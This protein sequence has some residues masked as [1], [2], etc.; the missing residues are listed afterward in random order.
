MNKDEEER[1]KRETPIIDGDAR[2]DIN[3]HPDVELEKKNKKA[4][5]DDEKF[6]AERKSDINSLEDYKD[7]Q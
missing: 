7:A 2:P 4:Q 5:K 1:E 3:L 6:K